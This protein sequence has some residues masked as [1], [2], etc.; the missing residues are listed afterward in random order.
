MGSDLAKRPS[1]SALKNWD[2]SGS[3]KSNVSS[4]INGDWKSKSNYETKKS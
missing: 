1:E 3:E 4:N 2:S